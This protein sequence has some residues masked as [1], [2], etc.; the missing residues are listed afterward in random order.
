MLAIRYIKKLTAYCVNV[1]LEKL[2][3]TKL[4]VHFLIVY[5]DFSEILLSKGIVFL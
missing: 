4:A 2:K 1:L 5:K 3:A